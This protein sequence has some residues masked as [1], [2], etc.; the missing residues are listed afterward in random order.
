MAKEPQSSF[1]AT[2][3][4]VLM[5][6]VPGN[7]VDLQSVVQVEKTD[8]LMG[9]RKV[10]GEYSCNM[11]DTW[12]CDKLFLGSTQSLTLKS[13]CAMQCD[14]RILESMENLAYTSDV[15]DELEEVLWD[16]HVVQ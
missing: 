7:E 12:R 13:S 10:S 14:V 15:V 8:A 5:H 6:E 3:P 2:D 1:R 16:Q 11:G 9:V 4:H